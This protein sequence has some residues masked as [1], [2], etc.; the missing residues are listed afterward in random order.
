[1]TAES[2]PQSE[3]VPPERGRGR[4]KERER[5]GGGRGRERVITFAIPKPALIKWLWFNN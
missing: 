4:G 2:W 5:E 3:P 1:M